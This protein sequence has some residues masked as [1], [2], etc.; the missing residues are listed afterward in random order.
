MICA[1]FFILFETSDQVAMG[2]IFYPFIILLSFRILCM[3]V[4]C[5]FSSSVLF[6]EQSSLL[7]A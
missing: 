1:T 2:G 4:F 5:V 6:D 3:C 7:C